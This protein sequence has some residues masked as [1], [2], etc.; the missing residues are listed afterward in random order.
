MANTQLF[1]SLRGL[2][3]PSADVRNEE[4][5]PAYARSPEQALALFAATGCLNGTFY[6]SAETQFGTVMKLCDRV[7]PDFVAR[8]AVYA[9]QVGHMKDMPALLLA[10]LASRDAV[11]LARAFP[12]VVDNARMLRNFVQVIRSG[13][14]GRKSLGTLPKRLVREWIDRASAEQLVQAAVGNNPSLADVIRMVHPKPDDATRAALYAWIIGKPFDENA[15]PPKVRAYEAFKREPHAALPEVPF[16]YL[17]S[18]KLDAAHWKTLARKVSWQTLRMSLNTFARN[19]VFNEDA[20]MVTAVAARLRSKSEIERARVF[21]YQL[22]A[23]WHAGI[24]LPG[25]IQLAMQDA[26]EIATRNVPAIDGRVVVAVD[27]SGSM[28]S[29]I[30]GYRKGSTS[31]MRCVDV[32]ALIAACLQ[33]T[34]PTAR[35]LPFDHIVRRVALN[36]RDSVMT[37]ATRLASLGGGGTAVSAPLLKLNSDRAEVDLLVIVSDNES[38]F[39]ARRGGPTEAMRQWSILKARC[40]KAKLVCI[41]LQPYMTSQLVERDDIVHV[42]GFS[43][44]VFDLLAVYAAEGA[45]AARWIDRIASI[46][47]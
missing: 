30:T 6:A 17:T 8:T 35:V 14:T 39:D 29:P 38:W 9:R 1:A 23:A 13:R 47:L 27:V 46:D 11:L 22:L 41:D 4:G 43:D 42:G 24:A 25:E 2:W 19:G 21:P 3:A 26:M 44:A 15:L 40:P 45:G 33:R 16:Q 34:N 5:A 31:S 12:H 37:Q 10:T 28:S 18:L 32:A 7:S 20:E 36:P